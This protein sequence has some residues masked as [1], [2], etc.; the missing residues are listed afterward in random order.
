MDPRQVGALGS[1]ST[2]PLRDPTA[3]SAEPKKRR[4]PNA[5]KAVCNA[6]MICTD[7]EHER[8]WEEVAGRVAIRMHERREVC[9]ADC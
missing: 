2:A 6:Y 4:D 8:K 9:D 7:T 3:A 1:V 5:P